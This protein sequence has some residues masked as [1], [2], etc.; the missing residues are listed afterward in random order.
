MKKST[1]N[2]RIITKEQDE[3]EKHQYFPKKKK[4]NLT[5]FDT[6]NKIPTLPIKHFPNK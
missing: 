1:Q 2:N 5:T 3:L 6:F 4:E